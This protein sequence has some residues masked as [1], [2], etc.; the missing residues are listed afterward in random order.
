M[1]REHYIKLMGYFPQGTLRLKVLNFLNSYL[2]VISGGCYIILL[3]YL[4][5]TKDDRF[6]RTATVP[7]FVFITVTLL[8][9]WINRQRPYDTL[10][11]KPIVS[12]KPGKGKS[13]PSRHTACGFVI[14]FAFINCNTGVGVFFLIIAFSIG[15]IRLVGGVHYPGDIIAGGAYSFACAIIGFCLIP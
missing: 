1:T 2:T 7:L 4:F 14:A 9:R 13:F 8:R 12:Y 3:T 15:I 11:F 6:V 10:Q 5:F